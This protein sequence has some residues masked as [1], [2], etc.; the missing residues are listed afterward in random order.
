MASKLSLCLS[1]RQLDSKLDFSMLL[2]NDDKPRVSSPDQISICSNPSAL[3]LNLDN[4]EI[5]KRNSSRAPKLNK[6]S[7]DAHSVRKICL[8]TQARYNIKLM[9][10]VIEEADLDD[11]EQRQI[12]YEGEV[13]SLLDKTRKLCHRYLVLNSLAIFIYKDHIAFNNFPEKPLIVIP[14]KEVSSLESIAIDKKQINRS[15]LKPSSRGDNTS[16]IPAMQ[17]QLFTSYSQL[18]SKF[19]NFGC[20]RDG[21][22]DSAYSL[23]SNK[24]NFALPQMLVHRPKYSGVIPSED[25]LFEF[26]SFKKDVVNRMLQSALMALIASRK[27]NSDNSL[28]QNSK[29]NFEPI[30]NNK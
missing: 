4:M 13:C 21:K 10:P 14:L 12:K 28:Q 2:G 18:Q 8:M 24:T 1:S 7:N 5:F 15:Q 26:A 19:I 11:F 17:V 29:R 16:T 20:K 27:A 25:F 30:Q 6:N 9:H 3:S 23:N 22:G